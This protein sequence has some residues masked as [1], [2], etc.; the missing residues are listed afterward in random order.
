MKALIDIIAESLSGLMY[1]SI[2][3]GV[4]IYTLSVI[5]MNLFKKDYENFF[6]NEALN[7]DSYGN[8]P[9]WNYQDFYHSFVLVFRILCGEWIELLWETLQATGGQM[10]PVLFY[11]GALVLGNFLLLNLFLALLLNA[12]GTESINKKKETAAEVVEKG[13]SLTA[14]L[15]KKLFNITKS[16]HKLASEIRMSTLDLSALQRMKT[17]CKHRRNPG[18]CDSPGNSNNPGNGDNPGNCGNQG[19]S[20]SSEYSEGSECK[21]LVLFSK[22]VYSN[23]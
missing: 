18:N 21:I 12:F 16:K 11:L 4:G 22:I 2:I 8:M 6:N 3:L 19:N 9:R 15:K 1:L 13:A 14:F 5:G 20:A 17:P 10:W 23:G 7:P